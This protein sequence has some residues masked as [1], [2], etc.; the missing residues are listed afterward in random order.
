MTTRQR[1][2]GRALRLP[3]AILAAIA[4][5]FVPGCDRDRQRDLDR[6]EAER[7]AK[8]LLDASL[9][10]PDKWSA[11]T[12]Y[13]EDSEDA[14]V[15]G[16]FTSTAPFPWLLPSGLSEA[17][18]VRFSADTVTFVGLGKADRLEAALSSQSPQGPK[19]ADLADFMAVSGLALTDPPREGDGCV[20]SPDA[21]AGTGAGDGGTSGGSASRTASTDADR[22]GVG[23]AGAG[24][25]TV[26]SGADP[27]NT[28]I[29][30]PEGASAD[31]A[32]SA[33]ARP[34]P[35]R[36]GCATFMLRMDSAV[37]KDIALR[38]A[39]PATSGSARALEFGSVAISN[40]SLVTA[41]TGVILKVESYE[42]RKAG[43]GGHPGSGGALAEALLARTTRS[44]RASGLSLA[45]PLDGGITRLSASLDSYSRKG[46]QGWA[47]SSKC[48]LDGLA[49]G[50]AGP[51]P[52]TLALDSAT[53]KGANATGPALKLAATVSG[54]AGATLALD[55]LFSPGWLAAHPVSLNSASFEGFRAEARGAELAFGSLALSGPLEAGKL[56][57]VRASF[58]GLSFK[59][60]DGET[61]GAGPDSGLGD[62]LM[63]IGAL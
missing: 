23:T 16:G 32:D 13:F 29:A 39:L 31:E 36:L 9:G 27:A 2:T 8:A 17:G 51:R 38:Q 25:G 26:G 19:G 7:A 1:I 20:R 63:I 35:A 53:L 61:A 34:A 47:A 58:K 6:A 52:M 4:L 10:G 3:S 46:A 33:D 48:S 54:R 12:V 43:F 14:L 42:A 18:R 40:L 11:S 45:L 21:R 24:A 41:R 22:N 55:E 56:S 37:L 57:D 44:E 59:A 60:P 15:Y 49:V 5:A 62:L 30:S 28:D 50:M